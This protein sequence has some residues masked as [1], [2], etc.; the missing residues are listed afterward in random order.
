MQLYELWQREPFSQEWTI[1]S[2]F[3][4]RKNAIHMMNKLIAKHGYYPTDFEICE[5][6]I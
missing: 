3:C 5:V 4:T 2:T 1:V 6:E